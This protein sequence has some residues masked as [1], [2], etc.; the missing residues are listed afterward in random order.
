MPICRRHI[1]FYGQVQGVGFR[2]HAKYAAD[3]TG[4]TGWV[5]NEDDGTVTMEIQGARDAINEVLVSVGRARF[6]WI[7]NMISKDIPIVPGEIRF[8]TR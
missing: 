1:T 7:E 4:C 6:V 2:Y 8:R 5:K 3:R